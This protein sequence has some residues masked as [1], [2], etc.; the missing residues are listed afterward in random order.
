[1]VSIPLQAGHRE[2]SHAWVRGMVCTYIRRIVV[3]AFPFH[4]I[5][6]SMG[7]WNGNR[8]VYFP[9]HTIGCGIPGECCISFNLYRICIFVHVHVHAYIM[10]TCKIFI[11]MLGEEVP[12]AD[13]ELPLSQAEILQSGMFQA[14]TS[15][16]LTAWV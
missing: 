14:S 3:E 5:E 10:Y 8:K 9:F 1:M 15:H 6:D 4:S 11:C 12:L 7:A 2:D 16:V 13:Y